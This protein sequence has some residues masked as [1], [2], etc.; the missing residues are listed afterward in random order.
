MSTNPDN[1]SAAEPSL[2]INVEK[3]FMIHNSE[4]GKLSSEAAEN[5]RNSHVSINN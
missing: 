2:E 1:L 5:H 4:S 3:L